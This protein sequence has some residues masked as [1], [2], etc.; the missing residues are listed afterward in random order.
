VPLQQA[1]AAVGRTALSN[2]LFTSVVCQFLFKWGPWKLYGALEYYQ[3]VYVVACV[4]A[5]NIAASVLWLRLFSFGPLEWLW[6]SL[7]YWKLQPLSVER[8]R[9]ILFSQCWTEEQ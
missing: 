3:Q 9:N 8:N 5:V 7:T 6:R 4:W 2:Y 1:L